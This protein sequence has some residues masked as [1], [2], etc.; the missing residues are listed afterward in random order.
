MERIKGLLA[1]MA[2]T[3]VALA[4]GTASATEVKIIKAGA[5]MDAV[6]VIRDKQ[7]GKL[8]A[9][10][11]EEMVELNNAPA[12]TLAPNI[13]VLSRPT[14][15]TVTRPDGSA[16]LR[17]SVEDLDSLVATRGADGKLVVRHK[18]D[19]AAPATHSAPKE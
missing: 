7:T 18:G 17:R 16:T 19:H 12:A 4:V 8:R 9:P 3:G 2:C 6:K 5:S 11:A 13:V 1:V 15:S 14:S 10:T